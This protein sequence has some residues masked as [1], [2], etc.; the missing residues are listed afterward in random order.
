MNDRLKKAEKILKERD[1]DAVLLSCGYNIRYF[2]GFSGATG[3]LYLSGHTKAVITDFRYT[4][5]AGEESPDCL[6]IEIDH[7]GYNKAINRLLLEERVQKLGIEENA[8]LYA[9][10]LELKEKLECKN[11]IP[12]GESF[13]ALRRIKSEDEIKSIRRAQAIGDQAFSSV[14]A[15]IKEGM[16][17]LELA[18][19]LEY[20]MKKNGAEGLSFDTI[21]A[22]GIHSSMPHAVPTNKKIEYGDF[23]TMDFGCVYEG[24]CSDMTRTIVVGKAG[25][26]QK[27]VYRT[28]LKAQQEALNSIHAGLT[29]K[30]IDAV[31]RNIIEAAGYKGCFGHGLGHSLG[32]F[33]HENPRLSPGEDGIIPAGAVETVEPGIYI[34]GFG[35]VRIEDLVLVTENGCENFTHSDKQ[36]IE[37]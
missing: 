14:L 31:A 4:I 13:T 15:L 8:M 20:Q 7:E 36:L 3:Y 33:I 29:G 37:L 23:V 9:D 19:E 34:K 10:Y 18:A 16:T 35:G 22:S 12:V 28:V 32:L 11:L 26:E 17:E 25:E 21:A 6:V 24:Y 2:S 30:E 27:K 5:Q 1:L